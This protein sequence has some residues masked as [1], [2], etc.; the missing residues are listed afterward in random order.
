MR[1]GASTLR[2]EIFENPAQMSMAAARRVIAALKAKPDL[3]LCAS[4]GWTPTGM[5]EQL[6]VLG[7]NQPRLFSRLRVLQIDEWGGLEADSPVSCAMDLESKL[8]RPLQIS[9]DRYFGFRANASD[10]KA[11][12]ERVA[13]WLEANGPIDLCI[14]GLGLNGH[15]AMNEPGKAVVPG[16]H[17]AQLTPSSRRHP[18]LKSLNKAPRFG[19]TLGVGD[20]LRSCQILLLVSG[21]HKQ[22]ILRKLL[23]TSKVSPRLPASFL[24]LH[25][26]ASLL[27][28]REAAG[29]LKDLRVQ[30][31]YG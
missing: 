15:I 21:K 9:E 8:L 2:L 28:D 29:D 1:A 3:L 26:N 27:C 18:M 17:K 25:G 30:K 13:S 31:T 20:I 23:T 7:A 5:Y 6:A 4:A 16:L 11:E 12:C 10:P 19:Y 22:K 24:W 14:L